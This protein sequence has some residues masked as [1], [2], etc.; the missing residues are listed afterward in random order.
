MF[1]LLIF[2]LNL[3]KSKWIFLNQFLSW[4]WE[5]LKTLWQKPKSLIIAFLWI[6]SKQLKNPETITFIF[7]IYIFINVCHY[8]F[9][10]ICLSFVLDRDLFQTVLLL[11]LLLLTTREFS[12]TPELVGGLSLE[13]E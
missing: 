6:L 5:K 12:F 8:M 13:T 4:Y 3:I 1:L 9:I 10:I 2:L 11:L 7:I